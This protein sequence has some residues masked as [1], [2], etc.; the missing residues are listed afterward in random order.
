[1]TN[2]NINSAA[3]YL[4]ALLYLS[5]YLISPFF[6][7]HDEFDLHGE[8]EKYHSHLLEETLQGNAQSECHNTIDQN[9]EHTHNSVLNYIVSTFSSRFTD[10][11][12]NTLSYNEINYLELTNTPEEKFYSND[13]HLEKTFK[14]RCIHTA[15]NVSPPSN[16]IS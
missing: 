16:F 7:F 2:K 3:F 14:D 8:E 10:I 13:F 11:P 1:M 15:S 4:V 6:H 9:D 12:S 5:Y